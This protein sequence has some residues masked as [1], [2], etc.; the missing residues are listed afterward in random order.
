VIDGCSVWAAATEANKTAIATTGT[1]MRGI[2]DA[3]VSL[4]VDEREKVRL[5]FSTTVT[6]RLITGTSCPYLRQRRPKWLKWYRSGAEKVCAACSARTY[7]SIQHMKRTTVFL[8]EGLERD[9]QTEARRTGKPMASLVREALAEYMA[10]RRPSGQRPSFVACAAGRRTDVSERHEQLLW[11][12]P[13][14]TVSRRP[15]KGSRKK[16]R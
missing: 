11:P 1:A 5:K 12:Q 8:S 13:H 6:M 3:Q 10:S 7:A 9:L 4:N 2:P 16:A 14:E 15:V